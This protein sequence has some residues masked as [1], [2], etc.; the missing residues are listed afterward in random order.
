MTS[1]N[2]DNWLLTLIAFS[3]LITLARI[4]RVMPN[5]SGE[6]WCPSLFPDLR[7]NAFKFLPWNIMLLN[8]WILIFLLAIL[9]PACI[10]SS[11]AFCMMYSAYK[12]NNQGDNIQS[13]V[14]LSHFE[15]VCHFM[16]SSNFLTCIQVSQKADKVVWYSHLFKNFP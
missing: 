8:I 4:F 16:S 11:L 12:L 6:S 9:I 10:S 13:D 7:G 1:A 14:L 2:R 5:R 3:F 15:P